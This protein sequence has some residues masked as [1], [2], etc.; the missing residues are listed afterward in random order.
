[1]AQLVKQNTS[2]CFCAPDCPPLTKPHR[3]YAVRTSLITQLPQYE[4]HKLYVPVTFPE[5][6]SSV[7]A[8]QPAEPEGA[9]ILEE[10]LFKRSP[11][12]PEP[13]SE[14]SITLLV[15]RLP[16]PIQHEWTN[17]FTWVPDDLPLDESDVRNCNTSWLAFG[18]PPS[19]IGTAFISP[20]PEWVCS[21]QQL[22]DWCQNIGGCF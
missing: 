1:V 21:D 12:V 16:G 10:T 18:I 2:P 9:P 15:K 13:I 20:A 19:T 11:P 8:W 22:R 14:Y 5:L 17:T 7:C 6:P 3:N 4:F